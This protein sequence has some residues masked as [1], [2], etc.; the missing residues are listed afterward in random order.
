[1]ESFLQIIIIFYCRV[2]PFL[3]CSSFPFLF[4]AFFS[5]WSFL[6]AFYFSPFH[7]FFSLLHFYCLSFL[8]ASFFFFFLST[9]PFIFHSPT[10]SWFKEKIQITQNIYLNHLKKELNKYKQV[11]RGRRQEC[12]F[13][14]DLW[15][16]YSKAIPRE[17][18]TLAEF[19]LGG[20]S[21]NDTRYPVDA[22]SIS[23]TERNGM[24]K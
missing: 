5:S 2:S 21:I 10:Y 13:L 11:E 3:F 20:H 16:H 9:L 12:I 15:N 23:G 8:V 7:S 1:M 22:M 17:V 24:N 18:D 19:I 6:S 4:S 14:L